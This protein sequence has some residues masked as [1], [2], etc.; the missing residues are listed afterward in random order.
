[1][2]FR[3]AAASMPPRMFVSMRMLLERATIAADSTTTCSPGWSKVN[4][5]IVKS[6][7]SFIS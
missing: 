1:M 3:L 6:G 2:S 7:L 5:T 4:F